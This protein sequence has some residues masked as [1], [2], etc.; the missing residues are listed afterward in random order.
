MVIAM[1]S[2]GPCWGVTGIVM[3]SCCVPAVRDLNQSGTGASSPRPGNARPRGAPGRTIQPIRR[4]SV[5]GVRPG[6]RVVAL[7]EVGEMTAHLQPTPCRAPSTACHLRDLPA[8]RGRALRCRCSY[9][10]V[11][12]P[13]ARPSSGR[14]DG[15]R[16][17]VWKKEVPIPSSSSGADLDSDSE[18]LL[19]H[20]RF[21]Q[22]CDGK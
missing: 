14:H 4:P 12:F 6:C 15:A 5:P 3:P 21:A 8:R 19:F 18:P 1:S 9:I 2:A 16:S 11:Q 10:R 17:T 13:T 22:S 20:D 7:R